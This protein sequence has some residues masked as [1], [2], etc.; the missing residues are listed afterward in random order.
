[1]GWKKWDFISIPWDFLETELASILQNMTTTQH[2]NGQYIH[3]ANYHNLD[4]NESIKSL[5]DTKS[6]WG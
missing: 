5:Y 4:E 1:M 6:N 2:C 3:E